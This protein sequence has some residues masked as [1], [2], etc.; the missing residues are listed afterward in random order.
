ML[1]SLLD[2]LTDLAQSRL[3]G[4]IRNMKRLVDALPGGVRHHRA[5]S[6]A[7]HRSI[8]PPISRGPPHTLIGRARHAP[9]RAPP[10][11]RDG[12]AGMSHC[13]SQTLYLRTLA[14][15]RTVYSL[16]TRCPPHAL[17][18]GISFFLFYGSGALLL[19]LELC[20][21]FV[22]SKS[23]FCCTIKILQD[24]PSHHDGG[25]AGGML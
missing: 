7:S 6:D 8:K 3:L 13:T 22:S 1:N 4:V 25:T 5:N 15:H 23:N 12:G 11:R 17:L 18:Y 9:R 14:P 20:L 16:W 10:S 2:S 24:I 19:H 21:S